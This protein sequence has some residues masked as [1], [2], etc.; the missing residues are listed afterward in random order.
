MKPK[1]QTIS[2]KNLN[3]FSNPQVSTCTSGT[4]IRIM[5]VAASAS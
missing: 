3:L 5:T 1:P 2:G 4:G